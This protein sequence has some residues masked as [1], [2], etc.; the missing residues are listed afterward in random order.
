[1]RYRTNQPWPALGGSMLIPPGTIID[2]QQS[3]FL[4]GVV[5]PPTVT[6]LD[7]ATRDWLVKFYQALPDH[8]H[9]IEQVPPA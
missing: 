6:P 8:R 9:E 2:D 7:A 4:R 3:D 1:M 5:P